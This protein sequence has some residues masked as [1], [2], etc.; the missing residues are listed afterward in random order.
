MEELLLMELS[1]LN[2]M[3]KGFSMS[4]VEQLAKGTMY[5]GCSSEE[6]ELPTVTSIAEVNGKVIITLDNGK[7]LEAT[8]DVV[9]KN[10]NGD[11][12]AKKEMDTLKETLAS[13]VKEYNALVE[14]V[15]DVKNTADETI[16][17]A[18]KADYSP[19]KDK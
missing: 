15:V 2:G 16:N 7:Y 9:D 6:K 18:F 8:L 5:C 1:K 17:K 14:N 12:E 13:L 11:I 19:N 10:I 3:L 4:C